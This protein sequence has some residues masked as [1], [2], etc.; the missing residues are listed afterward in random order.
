MVQNIAYESISNNPDSKKCFEN[1]EKELRE[2]LTN[3]FHKNLSNSISENKQKLDILNKKETLSDN[4]IK[5]KDKLKFSVSFDSELLKPK[6]FKEFINKIVISYL[7]VL[8]N[9]ECKG[10]V[11]ET[12]GETDKLPKIV[13]SQFE[14]LKTNK[15]L[16]NQLIKM[17]IDLRKKYYNKSSFTNIINDKEI[18]LINNN[19]ALSYCT[20][21]DN[22]KNEFISSFNKKSKSEKSGKILKVLNVMRNSDGNTNKMLNKTIKIITKK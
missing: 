20:H 2:Y 9:P 17:M 10:T 11:Y 22:I 6:K 4:E 5:M 18:N 21:D 8:C 14:P 15:K 7:S 12:N 1:I 16:Y 13:V 3:K 19:G